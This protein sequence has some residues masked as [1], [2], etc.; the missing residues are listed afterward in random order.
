MISIWI[1]NYM[2][3]YPRIRYSKFDGKSIFGVV[4]VR[5]PDP[6]VGCPKPPYIIEAIYK[7]IFSLKKRAGPGL[8]EIYGDILRFVQPMS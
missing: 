6:W 5:Q 2:I 1:M 8:D 7:I 3:Q 4:H